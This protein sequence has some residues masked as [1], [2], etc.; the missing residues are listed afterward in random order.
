[1]KFRLAFLA[2]FALVAV[3][4]ASSAF[5][6]AFGQPV[7]VVNL[8]NNSAYAG[9]LAAFADHNGFCTDTD[10]GFKPSQF[11]NLT[12]ADRNGVHIYGDTCIPGTNILVEAACTSQVKVNKQSFVNLAFGAKFDCNSIGR[13]CVTD[14]NGHGFCA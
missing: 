12:Y 8:D 1:M 13:S 4:L 11:G 2:L 3:P 9:S 14:A 7:A 6:A 5:H 10:N